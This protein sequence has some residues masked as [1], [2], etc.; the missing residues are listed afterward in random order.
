MND[1]ASL[2]LCK[3]L[4]ELS[5]WGKKLGETDFYTVNAR[6]KQAAFVRQGQVIGELSLAEWKKSIPA[7]TLG[8]LLRKLPLNIEGAFK[9]L[10]HYGTDNGY[11]VIQYCHHDLR[12]NVFTYS[13]GEHGDTP[14]DAACKLAIELFKQGVLK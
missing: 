14:E 10:N 1:V 3:E 13:Y 11:W 5:G 12:T 7:Y 9:E 8:Y 2:E 4:Y 6:G